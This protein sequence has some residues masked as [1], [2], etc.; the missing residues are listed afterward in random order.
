MLFWKKRSDEKFY[1]E[2]GDTYFLLK[3]SILLFFLGKCLKKNEIVK[4][5][6]LKIILIVY[7]SK[8][9]RIQFSVTIGIINNKFI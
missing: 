4:W 8:F 1:K 5:S 9:S 6:I 7:P 2:I 3:E